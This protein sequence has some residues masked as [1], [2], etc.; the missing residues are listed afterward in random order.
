[1]LERVRIAD[2]GWRAFDSLLETVLLDEALNFALK[3]LLLLKLALFHLGS[4]QSYVGF[5]FAGS[6][7][8]FNV[9][10]ATSHYRSGAFGCRF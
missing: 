1:M 8:L 10:I 3:F 4:N 7:W 9:L 5:V 6:R 2:Q